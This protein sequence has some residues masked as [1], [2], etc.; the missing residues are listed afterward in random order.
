M[1]RQRELAL[2]NEASKLSGAEQKRR[3]EGIKEGRKKQSI[4]IARNLLLI[5][6]ISIDQIVAVTGLTEGEIKALHF[7]KNDKRVGLCS[8]PLIYR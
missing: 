1:A 2:H 3:Q 7:W 6:N 8:C 4:E 5:E